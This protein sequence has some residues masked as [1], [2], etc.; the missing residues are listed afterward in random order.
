MAL[1]SHFFELLV[2]SILGGM[3]SLFF[4]SKLEKVRVGHQLKMAEIERR[5]QAHQEAFGLWSEM[6]KTND[7]EDFKLLHARCSS[8]WDNNCLYLDPNVRSEFVSSI[9]A[10]KL[11]H[12]L[13]QR[14]EPSQMT[15]ADIEKL[16]KAIF[17]ATLLPPMTPS[18]SGYLDSIASW[19]TKK[20]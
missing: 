5:L 20:H 13:V 3:V 11:H 8:W 19:I 14:D 12:D 7:N 1:I 15:F 9:T 16:H 2:A 10:M 6:I 17:E 4:S 18:E